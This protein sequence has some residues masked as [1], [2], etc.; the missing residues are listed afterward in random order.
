MHVRGKSMRYDLVSA[1]GARTPLVDVPHYDFKWQQGYVPAQPVI[2]R[3]GSKIECLATYDNSAN[4]PWNPDPAKEVRWGDQSWDE[5]MIGFM[6]IAFPA[7][8]DPRDILVDPKE[9][10]EAKR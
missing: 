5:M 3:A 8:V 7:K 1:S 10:A 6:E 2:V 4:N 9:L